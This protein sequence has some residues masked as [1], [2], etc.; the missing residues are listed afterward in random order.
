M[1]NNEDV[2]LELGELNLQAIGRAEPTVKYDLNISVTPYENDDEAQLILGFSYATSLFKAATIERFADSF[3][4]LVSAMLD[5]LDQPLCALSLLAPK[6][7]AQLE[8]WNETAQALPRE[9]PVIK[10]MITQAEK[11]P[12]AV[13]I[14]DESGDTSYA[15]LMQGAAVLQHA[16]Q[17]EFKQAPDSSPGTRIGIYCQPGA[18][19]MAAIVALL[20][21]GCSYVPI[22]LKSTPERI[23][24]II[25]N[26]D[27]NCVITQESLR[28][29]AEIN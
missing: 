21:S 23:G 24:Q 20:A 29:G 5:D 10:Q 14:K 12:E 16:L 8:Q 26:A 18:G 11:T 19:L 27:I 28:A 9:L 1:Q 22:E 15:Q 3:A 6:Q 4:V 25:E 7:L 13:A 2:A 17:L